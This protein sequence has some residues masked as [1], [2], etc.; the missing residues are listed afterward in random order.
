MNYGIGCRGSFA[1]GDHGAV[2][3]AIAPYASSIT[4]LHG[5]R[6]TDWIGTCGDVVLCSAPSVALGASHGEEKYRG[7][8]HLHEFSFGADG[9]MRLTTTERIIVAPQFR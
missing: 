4:I 6:H 9:R 8:F 7:S 1:V 2:L 5:H 3:A